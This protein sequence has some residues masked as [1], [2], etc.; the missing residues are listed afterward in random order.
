MDIRLDADYHEDATATRGSEAEHGAGKHEK[1]QVPARE[2]GE[3]AEQ[4]A[5]R[6]TE[7]P[8]GD[9]EEGGVGV[10]AI[11]TEEGREM[12]RVENDE[13]ED[14]EAAQQAEMAIVER[15]SEHDEAKGSEH[16]DAK[17]SEHDAERLRELEA[18]R[19]EAKRKKVEE[20]QK[21]FEEGLRYSWNVWKERLRRSAVILAEGREAAKKTE[22]EEKQKAEEV[23]RKATEEVKRKAEEDAAHL[24]RFETA[25]KTS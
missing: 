13:R 10:E 7:K 22:E 24:Q 14:E 16:D 2:T 23:R 12:V 1:Q 25:K 4:V 21:A 9:S 18:Q 19:E 11:A 3:G 15:V 6:E 20:A 8:G 5:A 17:G